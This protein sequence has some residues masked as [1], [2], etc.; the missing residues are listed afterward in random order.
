MSGE[1]LP[2]SLRTEIQ[3]TLVPVRAL[4]PPSRRV[5]ALLPLGVLIA[6]GVPLVW[7]LRLDAPVLGL[8]RLFGGSALEIAVALFVLAAALSEAVPARRKTPLALVLPVGL[9]LGLVVALTLLTFKVSA[10]VAPPKLRGAFLRICFSRSFGI[11]VIPLAAGWFLLR[12]GLVTRPV[13]AGALAGIGAGLLA[14]SGWR[15][16]CDVSDPI[17]VLTAHGGAILALGA[18]SA[19]LG[20]VLARVPPSAGTP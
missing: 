10:T 11:G 8:G 12:R 18:L 13:L 4:G 2:E 15:L 16:F 7:G 9:G 3:G 5:L 1:E 6:V 14:D 17:H 20:A 19:L